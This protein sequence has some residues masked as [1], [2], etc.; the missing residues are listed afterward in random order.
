M[1]CN[2]GVWCYDTLYFSDAVTLNAGATCNNNLT[3]ANGKA[4]RL[5]DIT[6]T[7]VNEV[8]TDNYTG[9]V[10]F[11]GS[12][13]INGDTLPEPNAFAGMSTSAIAKKP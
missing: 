6:N 1:G 5:A 4:L 13:S 7:F 9:S 12:D 11:T 3:I 10:M 2:E 8:F